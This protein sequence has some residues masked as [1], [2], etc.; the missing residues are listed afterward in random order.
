MKER[1]WFQEQLYLLLK[2]AKE[3]GRVTRILPAICKK[4]KQGYE[5]TAKSKGPPS[6]F[7]L[8]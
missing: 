4:N 2:S 1:R 8:S 3:V 5:M 7:F 6:A